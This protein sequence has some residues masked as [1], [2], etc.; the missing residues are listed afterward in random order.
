MS[1]EGILP[2]TN[3]LITKALDT[4]EYQF[5]VD[6]DGD[7]GGYWDENLFYFL[8]IGE[9]Q[10]VLLVRLR[11]QRTFG[12]DDIP[13]LYSFC[14]SWNDDKLWPKAYVKVGAG[15]AVH[16]YGELATDLEHGVALRQLD[17]LIMCA[18]SSGCELA[19]TVAELAL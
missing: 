12:T 8:R 11:A 10:E 3:D 9:D 2:L 16:V 7:V 17:Q 15:E 14:N 4:R 6:D 1:M 19:R 13:R 18:I 5:F